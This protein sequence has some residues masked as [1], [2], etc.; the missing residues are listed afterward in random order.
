MKI[1][2]VGHFKGIFRD[3]VKGALHS[4]ALYLNYYINKCV[5]I[6]VFQCV[7]VGLS[8]CSWGTELTCRHFKGKINTI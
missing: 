4:R 6:N 2:T 3:A 7:S 5:Y 1:V 8:C